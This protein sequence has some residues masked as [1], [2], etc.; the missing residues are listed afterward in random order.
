MPPD[1]SAS[2]EVDEVFATFR[3]AALLPPESLGAYVISMTERPSDVLAVE[4]LQKEART[5]SP[6]RVVALF[7]TMSALDAAGRTIADLLAILVSRAV[8]GPAGSDGRLLGLGEKDGGRLAASWALYKAGIARRSCRSAGVEPT[9]FHGRGGSVGRG[10]GPTYLAIQS[11]APGSV[12]LRLRVTEQGEMVQAKFGM[13]GLALRTLELYVTATLDSSLAPPA[14]PQTAW[15]ARMDAL[16]EH[17]RTSYRAVVYETEG[18]VDYF[19]AATPE[20]ELEDLT[21]GSRPARRREGGGVETLRAIPWVFAWTQT[22]LMLPSWLGVGE[23][24]DAADR[25]APPRSSRRCTRSG[26]SSGPRSI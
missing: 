26:R 25:R 1:L 10:G 4:L 20:S 16:A 19:R 2:P 22:R 11:Q 15:R 13:P 23:A 9:L 14:P 8:S 5:R 17:A 12:D 18:F 3:V 24:L 7:E 6:Q 21:I